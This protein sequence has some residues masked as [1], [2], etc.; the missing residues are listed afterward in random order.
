MTERWVRVASADEV[1]AGASRTV[2][3]E[4]HELSL[5]NVDGAIHCITNLCPHQGRSMTGGR[6]EGKLLTCPWHAWVFDVTTGRSPFS[7]YMKT[8]TFP[9]RVEGGEVLI[10]LPGPQDSR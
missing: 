5:H 3:V 4:G 2:E 8:R 9:V 10:G 6:L 1:P 7:E